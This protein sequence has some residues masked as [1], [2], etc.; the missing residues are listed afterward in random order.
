MRRGWR[1]AAEVVGHPGEPRKMACSRET[2]SALRSGERASVLDGGAG[3]RS[4]PLKGVRMQV[5]AACL[6]SLL[7]LAAC[8]GGGADDEDEASNQIVLTNV[9][10]EF[11][12][13]FSVTRVNGDVPEAQSVVSGDL[14]PGE[15]LPFSL[16]GG[17]Y[18]FAVT[19]LFN[20]A[21]RSDL[22]SCLRRN[23]RVEPLR[24][25]GLP[26][27]GP[28][29]TSDP[30]RPPK[31]REGPWPPSHGPSEQRCG[32]RFPYSPN[33]SSNAPDAPSLKPSSSPSRLGA[34]LLGSFALRR[35]SVVRRL[36]ASPA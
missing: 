19:W 20:S 23:R 1:G 36:A 26:R 11:V 16:P 35:K 4:G 33:I 5:R 9:D 21:D 30:A 10:T 32:V 27:A 29:R 28:P 17:K 25:A 6:A 31:R 7:M 13:F 8:G 14:S 22:R 12:E 3:E 24:P 2:A 15:S 34:P 18:R